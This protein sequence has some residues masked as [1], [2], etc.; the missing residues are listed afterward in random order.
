MVGSYGPGD[1]QLQMQV[2]WVFR[3]LAPLDQGPVP[4]AQG[5]EQGTHGSGHTYHT[6]VL[7]TFVWKEEWLTVQ[8]HS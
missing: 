7:C 1:S 2:L 4:T 5:W 3:C 8:Q 6:I